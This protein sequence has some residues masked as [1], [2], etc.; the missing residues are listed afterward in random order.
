MSPNKRRRPLA[1]TTPS[2]ATCAVHPGGVVHMSTIHLEID[3]RFVQALVAA[4]CEQ[5]GLTLTPGSERAK[6]SIRGESSQVDA[7]IA[8]QNHL[9]PML[10]DQLMTVAQNFIREHTGFEIRRSPR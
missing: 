1:S 6:L 5:L 3:D 4:L 9:L 10:D 7:L 2:P 8:R